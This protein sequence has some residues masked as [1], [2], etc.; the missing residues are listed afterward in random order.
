MKDLKGLGFRFGASL[1]SA[2]GASYHKDA[3]PICR[4]QLRPPAAPAA[5]GN[6]PNLKD[7]QKELQGNLFSK[8][9]GFSKG[10]PKKLTGCSDFEGFRN[11]K[12]VQKEFRGNLRDF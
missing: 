11:L 3:H 1:G 6:V 2:G 9:V 8:F 4:K 12:D 5:Y 7:F 10:V